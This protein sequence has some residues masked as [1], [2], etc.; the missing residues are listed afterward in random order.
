[1][2]NKKLVAILALTGAIANLGL[3]TAFAQ[4][5]GGTVVGNPT[6]SEV[7][8]CNTTG[9]SMTM[10]VPSAITFGTGTNAKTTN[11]VNEGDA[12]ATLVASGS[13]TSKI[14]LTSNVGFGGLNSDGQPVLCGDSF[15]L[16]VSGDGLKQFAADGKD[17]DITN[18]LGNVSG[19]WTQVS[20]SSSPASILNTSNDAGATYTTN[21]PLQP[22]NHS[23]TNGG[24]IS[25]SRDLISGNTG[26]SGS[27]SL[28]LSG[29]I[30]NALAGG[31]YNRPTVGQAT[32]FHGDTN[33]SLVSSA[34]VSGSYS[35]TVT[36]TRT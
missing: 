15:T 22:Y 21:A 31:I 29:G 12:P 2:N 23:G 14:V 16:A 26:F 33:A 24:S 25:T 36:F 13:D 1:M 30:L 11:M 8:G 6:G 4:T 17:W 7:I 28:E 34:I 18:G 3:A 19:A 35:G 32:S 20:G 9:G 27:V 10:T 5:G